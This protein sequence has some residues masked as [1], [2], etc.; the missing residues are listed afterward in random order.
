[1]AKKPTPKKPQRRWRITYVRA[2]GRPLGTVEAADA[3]SAIQEAAKLFGVDPG[4]LIAQP[5][6]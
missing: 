4:R 1:M 3:A 2:K 5:M 6:E